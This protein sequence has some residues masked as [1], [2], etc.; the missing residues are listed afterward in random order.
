MAEFVTKL[1]NVSSI[2]ARNV[3]GNIHQLRVDQVL[4]ASVA[5]I[6]E[7]DAD[8]GQ[9][10]DDNPAQNQDERRDHGKEGEQAPEVQDGQR[11]GN[12]SDAKN[13]ASHDIRAKLDLVDV[14]LQEILG[15]HNLSFHRVRRTAEIRDTT[16]HAAVVSSE[17]CDRVRDVLDITD[18]RRSRV[19]QTVGD[20]EN[21]VGK[22]GRANVNHEATSGSHEHESELNTLRHVHLLTRVRRRAEAALAHA[23]AFAD[24]GEQVEAGDQNHRQ[25]EQ[26]GDDQ[27]RHGLRR[28]AQAIIFIQNHLT[29]VFFLI[30]R[31]HARQTR[32]GLGQRRHVVINKVV[33]ILILPRV[34]PAA[35]VRARPGPAA[36]VIR[37]KR[38]PRTTRRSV[39]RRR[40]R[41]HTRRHVIP[42]RRLRR[43]DRARGGE[44]RRERRRERRRS[45]SRP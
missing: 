29:R 12:E 22:I 33:R 11:H 19:D 17:T 9:N 27:P 30:L 16:V 14:L 24:G 15:F 8:R 13:D 2:R 32:E 37:T 28:Q 43:G 44:H 7:E 45:P 41:V 35:R 42:M 10:A 25:Q 4:I 6:S 23:A 5:E 18:Q 34:V 26:N 3:F 36:A 38:R 20:V 31:V 39:T 40:L 21:A 1:N